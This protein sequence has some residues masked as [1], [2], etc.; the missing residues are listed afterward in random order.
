[1]LLSNG[2]LDLQINKSLNNEKNIC[3]LVNLQSDKERMQD[4]QNITYMHLAKP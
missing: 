2:L 3:F 1:V 4:Y